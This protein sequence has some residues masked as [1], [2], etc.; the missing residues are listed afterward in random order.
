MDQ[1]QHVG[2]MI[3]ACTHDDRGETGFSY[4]GIALDLRCGDSQLS[5]ITQQWLDVCRLYYGQ[6]QS[7][8][9]ISASG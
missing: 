7:H 1:R 6:D 2:K 3:V 8:G 9:C 5:K 4:R